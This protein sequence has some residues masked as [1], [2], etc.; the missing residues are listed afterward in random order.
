[1]ITKEQIFEQLR[2]KGCRITKQRAVLIDV[3]LENKGG[4]CK[5][6]YYKAIKRDGSIGISTVYRTVRE[7]EKM[8]LISREYVYRLRD[9]FVDKKSQ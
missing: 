9:P 2:E 4:S 6:I 1:M 7:L 8:G 3:I 5:E